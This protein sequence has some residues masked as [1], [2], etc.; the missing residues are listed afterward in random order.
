MPSP[1]HSESAQSKSNGETPT[2]AAQEVTST[3]LLRIGC[4]TVSLLIILPTLVLVAIVLAMV[5]SPGLYLDGELTG[6][7]YA[8]ACTAVAVAIVVA[9]FR[10]LKSK[11]PFGAV[12][13]V[14][15]SVIL[16]SF[17]TIALTCALIWALYY[18]IDW[19]DLLHGIRIG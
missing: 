12:V 18:F 4:S 5:S 15:G 10:F 3:R 13:S 19:K 11:S 8:L 17:A 14:V 7:S 6:N 9:M 16:V 1:E 2:S